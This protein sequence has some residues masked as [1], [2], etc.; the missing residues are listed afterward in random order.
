MTVTVD[1]N[2]DGTADPATERPRIDVLKE[3]MRTVL[4][5]MPSLNAGLMRSHY[6]G[7]PILYP[8]ANLDEQAC[9]V[10]GNCLAAGSPTGIQ[11]VTTLISDGDND[12]EEEGGATTLGRSALDFGRRPAGTC[13]TNRGSVAVSSTVTDDA[14]TRNLINTYNESTDLQIPREG[15]LQQTIGIRFQSVPIPANA[16]ITDAR[17]VFEVDNT[18]VPGY[19]APIDILISGES[20]AGSRATFSTADHPLVRI[21]NSTASVVDWETGEFPAEGETLTTSNIAA[22]LNELVTDAAWPAIGGADMVFFLVKDPAALASASGSRE[23]DATGPG[24][25]SPLLTFEYTTCTGAAADVVTGLRFEGVSIPQ[26]STITSA[27][28]DFVAT[29]APGTGN[30][31]LVVE[32]E[33]VDDAAPFSNAAFSTRSFIGAPVRGKDWDTGSTPALDNSWVV[34]TTYSTP[35][36]TDQVQKIVERSGW[37]G[38]NAMMFMVERVG[39]D[40]VFRTAYSYEADSALAPRLV[41]TYDADNPQGGATGCIRSTIVNLIEAGTDDAEEAADGSME[42]SGTDLE[43]VEDSSTQQVGLRFIDIPIAQGT[44]ITSAK[45]VFTA[46]ETDSGTTSLTFAGQLSPD[47]SAFSN[48]DN[49]ISD[50]GNRPRTS[51]TAAWSPPAFAAEGATYEATGIGPIVQEIVNQAGWSSGNSLAILISGSGKRVADSWDGSPATAPRLVIEFEGTPATSKRTVRQRLKDVVSGL[52]QRGGTPIAGTMIEAARYFRGEAV[53][54]GRQRGD[55]SS[56]DR[57]TNVSHAASY[58]A[59]G[60]VET[61]PGDCSASNLQDDDCKTQVISGGSPKYKSP[62]TAEC[63]KNYLIN[64]TDGAGF[65]TGSSGDTNT[66]GLSLDEEGIINTFTAED[67]DGNSVALT[68]CASDTTLPDGTVYSSD[69]HNECAVK[70]AKFLQDNDQIYTS[71]Q[72]LQSG[73]APLNEPQNIDVYTIG[74]NLCGTGN[75]TSL[76]SGG[77]QVCCAVANHDVGT[78]ICSAPISDPDEIEMLKAM[79]AVGGGEY[80]NAN[81]VDDLV[82]AFTAITGGIIEKNTSFVAPSIAANAFN[83]LFSRD[84]VYFGMFEPALQ[85]RWDGNLKKYNVCINTDPNDD[86]TADCVL[87]DVLDAALE[88]AIVDDVNAVDNGLF[89]VTAESEWS[90]A[91]DGR[92]IREGG[93]GA[94]IT[95]YTARKIYTDYNDA[96]GIAAAGTALSS[97]GYFVTSANW[98]A[99]ANSA[100]RD[101]VCPTPSTT[102]G[103]DCETRMLW[104]LGKDELDSDNDG[105]TSDTRW[106]FHDVLH[107]SPIAITYG[108]D[109]SNNFIDKILVSSNEGGLHFINGATGVEEWSFIPRSVLSN[110]Q[111]LFDNTGATHIYGLDSTPTIGIFDEN[112]DG[113]IDPATDFIGAVFTQRRGGDDIYALNL[114]PTSTL[115]AVSQ[116]VV[117]KFLWEISAA[118][119]GFSRLGQTWSEPVIGGLLL[120]DETTISVMIFAGGYD[121]DLDLDDGSGIAKNFGTEAGSPNQGNAIYIVN[122]NTGDLIFSI[123]GIGS[124]ANIEVPG[125]DYAIPSNVNAFDSNGDDRLDR[126]YVGDSAGQVWRVDLINVDPSSNPAPQGDTVVGRLANISVA[127]TLAS[128]RR[129]FYKPTVVQVVDTQFSN[130]ADGEY[131][132]VLIGSGNRANPLDTEVN[133][134]FYAFRDST[135][136]P[137]VD[138][139]SD[140]IADDYPLNIDATTNGSPITDSDLI[141]VTTTVL[142]GT[143]TSVRDSLGWYYNFDSAGTDG[144]KVLAASSVFAGTLI[145]T[146][147]IPDD[148]TLVADQCTA[149]EG[150]GRAYNFNI[151]ST[152]AAID[153]DE[154]GTVEDREDVVADLEAGIP[155]EGV[156][157]FTKEGVTVLVG[158]GG[159]AENLGKVSEL[160]RIDTYWYEENY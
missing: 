32:M 72:V 140:N 114:T 40:P 149:A 157:I 62:I 64:L 122:A 160:P 38:G 48:S 89:A 107:S 43:M 46:D 26:G 41:V 137:M 109:A 153:W 126:I 49:D 82:A 55:Q 106:W 146:S 77:D 152:K 80:Y 2:N 11:T 70:L 138:S 110:Q 97:S 19:N 150:T 76:D 95:D 105:D 117:P 9:V 86:G 124:G 104:M 96:D 88:P 1:E 151:L 36:L 18:S 147:Y 148:P 12:A 34:D 120:A 133:D 23:V 7:G 94:E 103:S 44:T 127:G 66:L 144:E 16:T 45:L 47:A 63:Q 39:G 74:F 54:F 27:R 99:T 130:A 136:G 69:S 61:F 37:C 35:D 30:P 5:S 81:T 98:D 154:D 71:T 14:E 65:F 4:D 134:R 158:T 22:I 52:V 119:T 102:V 56:S 139:N 24:R 129:F 155:S 93:A 6:H 145:F 3:A 118:T 17:L 108:Q 92:E 68:G 53:H 20:M 42:V 115:T 159:G 21:A 116:T 59:N 142:D 85:P 29:G 50:T 132:Y 73:A 141:D 51:A 111:G 112:F 87:G 123:S 15:S 25:T 125:M 101:Q 113:T 58:Q 78:G 100:I 135:I 10:E 131:D 57:Y 13:T 8:V 91:A 67:G 84:D 33:E 128:E 28:I 121:S 90:G 83:R 79:A 143:N 60:A 75:V 156:P 31:D